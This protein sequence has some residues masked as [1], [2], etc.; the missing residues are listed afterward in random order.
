[1]TKVLLRYL[2]EYIYFWEKSH[3]MQKIPYIPKKKHWNLLLKYGDFKLFCLH[4]VTL[5][6]FF[7]RNDVE[8]YGIGLFFLLP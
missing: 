5:V 8:Q 7:S 1:M 4:V 2:T 3:Q 6:F